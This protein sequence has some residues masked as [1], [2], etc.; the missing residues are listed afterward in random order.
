MSDRN[1]ALRA[2]D[3]CVSGMLADAELSGD[4]LLVGL[5]LAR[6]VHLNEPELPVGTAAI[7]QALFSKE[8]NP[9]AKVNKVLRGD[10]RRYTPM[11]YRWGACDAPMVRRQ[12]KCGVQTALREAWVTDPANGERTR[13]HA[14]SRP[15]HRQWLARVTADNE[16]ALTAQPD[17][18]PPANIGGVL[19]K[20]LDEIDWWAM[21]RVLDPK[22]TPPPEAEPFRKPRLQLLV[23][24]DAEVSVAVRPEL[25]VIEGG[26]R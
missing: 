2:Y 23:D 26:W 3:A 7:A 18:H 17:V 19:S 15:A 1:S 8:Y 21:W 5:F 14:C 12:G 11:G 4:L 13:L 16:R 10:R 9:A 22:W 20:H 24:D 6:A 25:G